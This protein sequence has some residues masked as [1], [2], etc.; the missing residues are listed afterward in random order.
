MSPT[1]FLTEINLSS[2]NN[3]KKLAVFGDIWLITFF[4]QNCVLPKPLA[5]E[6]ILEPSLPLSRFMKGHDVVN[7][8][9]AA[10]GRLGNLAIRLW[11]KDEILCN[12]KD[13]EL[14]SGDH[15]FCQLKSRNQNREV[16]FNGIFRRG[17]EDK[18]SYEWHINSDNF[19][20]VSVDWT[21]TAR[22]KRLKVEFQSGSTPPPPPLPPPQPPPPPPPPPP[23]SPSPQ[24]P[25]S[26]RPQHLS[27]ASNSREARS[28]S[29]L[30]SY[31]QLSD[32]AEPTS[33]QHTVWQ[34]LPAA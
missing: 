26:S 18:N 13:S 2:L 29:S 31:R 5:G 20:S 6:V 30:V 1:G 19:V 10:V 22:G 21:Q 25:R 11:D 7:I 9:F 28:S 33:R 3:Y 14:I 8:T 12:W 15:D 32:Q 4:V 27:A 16:W 24:Q 17:D 23:P 34:L